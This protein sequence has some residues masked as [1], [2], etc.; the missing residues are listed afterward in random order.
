MNDER[1]KLLKQ[2]AQH[3]GARNYLLSAR[4][5][6]LQG[7]DRPLEATGAS[8]APTD[9][10]PEEQTSA[11]VSELCNELVLSEVTVLTNCDPEAEGPA[12][13]ARAPVLP[14][15]KAGHAEEALDTSSQD[16]LSLTY[17]GDGVEVEL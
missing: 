16:S 13:C 8:A 11:Q 3:I 6:V 4:L 1:A 9:K 17:H 12:E 10:C 15:L 5:V 2:S 7:I 14:A